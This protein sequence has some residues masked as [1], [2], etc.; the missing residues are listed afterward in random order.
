MMLAGLRKLRAVVAGG[1]RRQD[2]VLEGMKQAPQDYE[3]VVLVHDAA[4]PFVE[5]ALIDAV[6]A[7]PPRAAAPPYRCCRW[8]TP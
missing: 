4:R 3:G 8:S 6:V 7:M 2:S 5:P 1:A